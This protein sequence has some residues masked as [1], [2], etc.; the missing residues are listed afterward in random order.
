MNYVYGKASVVR[1]DVFVRE[2]SVWDAD[3]PFVQRHPEFFDADPPAHTVGRT[4]P[5]IEQATAGP[6]ES[7]NAK[8]G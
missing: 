7:R 5:L 1:D 4:V 2:G 8:R 3:D 6:G